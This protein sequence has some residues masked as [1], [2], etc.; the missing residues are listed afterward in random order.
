MPIEI[1]REPHGLCKKYTGRVLAEEIIRS[2]EETAASPDFDNL[3][4]MLLDFTGVSSTDVTKEA[5]DQIAAIDL[6]SSI[7]NRRIKQAIVVKT[8]ELEYLALLYARSP[9]HHYETRVFCSTDKARAWL[10]GNL[11]DAQQTNPAGTSNV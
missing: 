11:F 10:G 4:Y 1:R 6:G 9:L 8:V 7:T 5:I 3:R 2:D